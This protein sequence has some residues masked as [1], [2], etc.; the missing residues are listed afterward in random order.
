MREAVSRTLADLRRIETLSGKGQLAQ[1]LA[2]AFANLEPERRKLDTVIRTARVLNDAGL[3]SRAEFAKI[4]KKKGAVGPKLA[5]YRGRLS[6]SPPDPKGGRDLGFLVKSLIAVS[7]VASEVTIEAWSAH[8]DPVLTQA[9]DAINLAAEGQADLIGEL[10]DLLDKLRLLKSPPSDVDALRAHE[11]LR[12]RVLTLAGNMRILE[13]PD[14]VS[15]FLK[16]AERAQGAQFRMLTPEVF[17]WV[18]GQSEIRDSLR[19]RR[20]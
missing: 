16:A 4:E 9:G 10:E 8:R 20:S 18:R 6:Q 11:A 14:S 1:E 19:I 15:T 7:A 13:I 5:K 2:E 3:I 12:E 17:E